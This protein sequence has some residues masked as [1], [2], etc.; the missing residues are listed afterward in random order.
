MILCR[1]E[2]CKGH[3]IIQTFQRKD[4]ETRKYIARSNSLG[5][6]EEEACIAVRMKLKIQELRHARK[7]QCLLRKIAGSY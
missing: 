1:Y 6:P 7:M 2:E 5:N 4:R 3:E